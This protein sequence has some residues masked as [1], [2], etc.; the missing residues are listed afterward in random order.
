MDKLVAAMEGKPGDLLLFAA[1]KNKIVWDVLGNLR[2]ELARQLDLLKKDD[3]RFLWVTEFPLLEYSE[4]QGRFVAMHHPFTMPMEEDW[5][6]IDSDPGAVRAKAYDIVLNGTELGGGS[7]RIH[8]NDIQNKM[9]EVLGFTPQ[10]AQEQFGFLLTAFKYGVPPHA[11]LAYGLDRVAMLMGGCDSIREVIAFP[12][13]KDASCLMCEAPAM[14]DE[15]QLEELGIEVSETATA[16][17]ALVTE[18]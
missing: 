17:D 6:L 15:K 5:H 16:A 4:E 14:V 18:K 8:Q 11:G 10:Q 3:F 9:F 7:V 12:K 1:D 2:L 13:V